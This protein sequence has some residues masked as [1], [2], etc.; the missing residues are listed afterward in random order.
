MGMAA[1]QARLLCITARK[2]SNEFQGQQINQ[3]RVTL[4][5]NANA[6]W[7][8]ML[9]IQ[10]PTP[11]SS[12]DYQKDIYQFTNED[13]AIASITKLIK[14]NE[15]GPY[16]YYVEYE[17]PKKDPI[18]TN[19]STQTN[20]ITVNINQAATS[21]IYILANNNEW[22]RLNQIEKDAITDTDIKNGLNT[23]QYVYTYTAKDNNG[24]DV[25]Y[26]LGT[27]REL[28]SYNIT[29]SS[30]G[31]DYSY[32]L[33][34]KDNNNVLNRLD[35][36]KLKAQEITEEDSDLFIT[37]NEETGETASLEYITS[38]NI[39]ENLQEAAKDKF[40][41]RYTTENDENGEAI[42]QYIIYNE[43]LSG[44]NINGLSGSL[45]D[46][47][48]W[49]YTDTYTDEIISIRQR[50]N[51]VMSPQGQLE[52]I[53]FEDGT[54]YSLTINQEIDDAAYEK[55]MVDYNYQKDLYDKEL[56][57][58]NARIK[59]I[60]S[61]DQIL[62]VRLKNIDTEHKALETEVDAIKKV[63]DKN[64]ETSFKTFA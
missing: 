54:H 50:A 12:Q 13:G 56:N 28:T 49:E 24:N 23:S 58:M 37:I 38:E 10:V 17:V 43:K 16:S 36:Q 25:Q 19:S 20:N 30:N 33:Y 63:L 26:Y 5:N 32:L 42:Y 59:M 27:D 9:T 7:M 6:I 45:I 21:D 18:L 1:S 60:Q 44:K 22:V 35:S 3:Q 51:I 39:P 64:I 62:E 15:P 31:G 61:Q 41:Y 4:S 8:N 40:V 48:K 46:T 57:D 53:Y 14:I 2:S 47:E 34:Y 55:A 11:P 52:E 29:E